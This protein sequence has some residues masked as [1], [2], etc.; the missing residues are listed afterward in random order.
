[1]LASIAS[2]APGPHSPTPPAA[3]L[4]LVVHGR[5]AGVVP[6][7][8]ETLAAELAQ[9]RRSSVQLVALTA[10]AA[11][12]LPNAPAWVMP[13]FLLPGG[14]VRRDVP[15]L[16]AAWCGEGRQ[17]RRLPF[18][19]AWPGW[20]EA[21]A[22]EL[23]EQMAPVAHGGCGLASAPPLL[24]HH[25]LDDPLAHRY[26]A[27]L[28]RRC[29]AQT[30]PAPYSAEANETLTLPACSAVLPLTLAANRLTERNPQLL[31]PPLLQ[32][33]RFRRVVLN[34]LGELP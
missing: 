27:V 17:L 29:A 11:P 9:R 6:E 22:A 23:A 5:A 26:L 31:G 24:L 3:P 21:L 19:G 14:H 28:A 32:R 25:P 20:L 4:V 33:P 8:L 16:V 1:L 18:L 12:Q 7:E 15:A 30:L 34:L 2:H 13:L 10:C